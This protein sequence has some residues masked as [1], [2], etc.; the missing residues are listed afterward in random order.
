M[1]YI[2][3]VRKQTSDYAENIRHDHMKLVAWVMRPLIPGN[4]YVKDIV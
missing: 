1:I 4:R 2:L 3:Y